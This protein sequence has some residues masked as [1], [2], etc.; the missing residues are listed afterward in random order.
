MSVFLAC[1]TCSLYLGCMKN[2]LSINMEIFSFLMLIVNCP[3]ASREIRSK[4]YYKFTTQWCLIRCSF[5]IVQKYQYIY[6]SVYKE[7]LIQLTFKLG[8]IVSRPPPF[9]FVNRCSNISF[10]C[11]VKLLASIY[12]SV[13]NSKGTKEASLYVS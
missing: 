5:P 12:T 11:K 2:L 1:S 10:R 6:R 7:Q 3:I 9:F 8:M 13:A 4:Q